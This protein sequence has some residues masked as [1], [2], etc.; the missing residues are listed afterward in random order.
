MGSCVRRWSTG[1]NSA[2]SSWECDHLI[3]AVEEVG[4]LGRK[5][6]N[7]LTDGGD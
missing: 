6:K 4:R 7:V 3:S 2:L 1:W 5:D